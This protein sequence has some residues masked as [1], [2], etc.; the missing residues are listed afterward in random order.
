MLN[1]CEIGGGNG[2]LLYCLERKGILKSGL[3]YEVSKNRC[4]LAQKFSEILL[5]KNVKNINCNFLEDRKE[6][7]FDCIIMVDIVFQLISP[8]YDSA[9]AEMVQWLRRSLKKG[10][11]LFLEIIDYSD[12]LKYIEKE[13]VLQTWEEFPEEDPFQY[14]LQKLSIDKDNNLV[15]EKTFIGRYNNM[16]DYFK[17]VIRSYTPEELV[18]L[19]SD[20]RFK[21]SVYS[22]A[23]Q[24]VMVGK[25]VF[26]ILAK[27]L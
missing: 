6:N 4:D 9:E 8:L 7:E 23:G 2:K 24:D 14:S 25:N 18:K 5:S 17:N 19:F 3:N 11:S 22:L 21:V 26:R 1:V 13:N 20:N 15:N 12:I 27:K 16:R 10:G